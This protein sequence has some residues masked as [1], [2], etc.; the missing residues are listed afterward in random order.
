MNKAR[1]FWRATERS[2]YLFGNDYALLVD[3]PNNPVMFEVGLYE[4]DYEEN[5]EGKLGNKL[6]IATRIPRPRRGK[7]S[8]FLT[9]LTQRYVDL[10]QF[11][12]QFY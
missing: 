10:R 5:Y 11:Y 3:N 1:L 7:A 6:M 2:S 12:G 9:W 4:E 8:K